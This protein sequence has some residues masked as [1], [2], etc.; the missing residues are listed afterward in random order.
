MEMI[1]GMENHMKRLKGLRQFCIESRGVRG[2]C[3]RGIQIMNGG[4]G[5]LGTP[6]Y[7]LT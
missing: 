7:P 1:K 4:K 6:V 2:E 3:V 5:K